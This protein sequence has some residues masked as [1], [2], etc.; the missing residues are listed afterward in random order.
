MLL[1]IVSLKHTNHIFSIANL[2]AAQVKLNNIKHCCCN[3][4]NS[5]NGNSKIESD[6]VLKETKST[7]TIKKNGKFVLTI[8]PPIY[9]PTKTDNKNGNISR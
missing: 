1:H 5:I 7:R 2:Y 9:N 8:C 4:V 3:K 6:D